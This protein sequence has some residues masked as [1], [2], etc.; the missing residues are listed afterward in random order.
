MGTAEDLGSI[1]SCSTDNPPQGGQEEV[2]PI[3]PIAVAL[4]AFTTAVGALFGVWLW[5]LVIGLA[6]VLIATFVDTKPY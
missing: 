3:N 5:G 2:I 1:P 4:V 6:I